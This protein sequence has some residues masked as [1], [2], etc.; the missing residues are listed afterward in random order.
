[1]LELKAGDRVRPRWDGA[2]GTVVRREH[3]YERERFLIARDDGEQSDLWPDDDPDLEE[4][5][6]LSPTRL[7]L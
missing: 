2:L 5:L 1:M 4:R 3:D 7:A 6:Q